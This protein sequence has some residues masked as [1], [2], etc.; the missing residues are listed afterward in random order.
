MYALVGH[1]QSTPS[2]TAATTL[3]RTPA[4]GSG[5]FL[6]IAYQKNANLL[7]IASIKNQGGGIDPFHGGQFKRMEYWRRRRLRTTTGLDTRISRRHDLY[8]ADNERSAR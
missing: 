2:T 8:R 5:G 4:A 3:T 6:S 1:F 7:T